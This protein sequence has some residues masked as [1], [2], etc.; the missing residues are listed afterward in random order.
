VQK[1]LLVNSQISSD[2]APKAETPKSARDG[3]V[4]PARAKLA[5]VGAPAAATISS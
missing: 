4:P 3:A 5:V 2:H 1:R